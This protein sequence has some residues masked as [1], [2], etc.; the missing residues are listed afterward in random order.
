M[1]FDFASR[2]LFLRSSCSLVIFNCSTA[3]ASFANS[4]LS[5][6]IKKVAISSASINSTIRKRLVSFMLLSVATCRS[7]SK[8]VSS[9][10]M[11]L[12][13]K[14]SLSIRYSDLLEASTFF[15]FSSLPCFFKEI[16]SSVSETLRL[17]NWESLP[18]FFC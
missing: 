13:N 5:T 8:F 15:I 4:F 2:S 6:T 17:I 11:V 18:K 12:F 14:E 1:K 9:A 16:N 3:I 10:C 7:A